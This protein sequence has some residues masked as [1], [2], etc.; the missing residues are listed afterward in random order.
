MASCG[1]Q[2]A[3]SDKLEASPS[4]MLAPG[5]K[6]SYTWQQQAAG[7]RTMKG[8]AAWEKTSPFTVVGAESS[9]DT[10]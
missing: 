5:V 6:D 8:P 9:P 7:P 10:N 1:L 2:H 4:S 3:A